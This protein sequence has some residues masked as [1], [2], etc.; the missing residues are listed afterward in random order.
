MN[1]AHRRAFALG[2]VAQRLRPAP[3]GVLFKRL[4]RLRRIEV[5][6]PAGTFWVDPGSDIGQRVFAAGSYDP[7]AAALIGMCLRPGDT[8]VDVGANEGHL[9]V[10]AARAVG[11]AGRVLAVEPQSRLQDVLRR[12][13]ALNGVTADILPVAISDREGEARLFLAPDTNNASSGLAPSTRYRVPSEAVRQ[14]TLARLLAERGVER[15]ALVK[16]DI[17]GFEHEAIFGSADLFRRRLLPRLLLE[18]HDHALARRGHAPDAIPRF[19]ADCGYRQD[20]EG[21]GLLWS[22]PAA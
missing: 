17:E 22:A 8:Y 3:L 11:P 13:L 20:P 5:T 10:C 14:T 15:P 18:L 2:R 21:H 19:L 16:M 6:T 1:A 9:C 7:E 12:N 4:V